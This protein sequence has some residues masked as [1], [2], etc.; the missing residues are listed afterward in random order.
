VVQL[1]NEKFVSF[2]PS[3]GG[4]QNKYEW[5]VET[6][7]KHAQGKGEGALPGTFLWMTTAAGTLLT[8]KSKGK[9]GQAESLKEV[10]QNYAKLP[11]AE[12]RP[13]TVEGQENPVPPPPS[14]GLVLTVFDRILM[15]DAESCCQIPRKKGD[16]GDLWVP[17]DGQRNSIWLT[18]DE[19]ESLIPKDPQ[20]GQTYDVPS[21][22][23]RRLWILGLWPETVWV[24]EQRWQPDCVRAGDSS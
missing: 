4:N 23:A 14:G 24:V 10:L 8:G 19:C 6:R 5:F 9:G 11:E 12:R 3:W 16:L 1:L 17:K 15:R 20:K 22:L 7:K 18:K 21:K 13:P 2:A